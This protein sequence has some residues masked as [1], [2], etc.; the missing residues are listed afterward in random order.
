MADKETRKLS[1]FTNKIREELEP[2]FM[3]NGT[4]YEGNNRKL[5]DFDE[6]SAD[7]VRTSLTVSIR[8]SIFLNSILA[9]LS[10]SLSLTLCYLGASMD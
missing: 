3:H 8:I 10:L 1:K 4:C 6:S 5:S 2:H 7:S 9:S